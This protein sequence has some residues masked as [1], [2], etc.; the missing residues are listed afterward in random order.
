MAEHRPAEPVDLAALARR[1]SVAGVVWSHA[2]SDLN[3][4]FVLFEAGEG[5][6]EHVNDEVEV[7]VVA[8]VGAGFVEV[9]GQ[10]HDLAPGMVIAI[11][12]G[13]RRAIGSAGEQFGYLTC[14]RRRAWL[15]PRGLS[16]PGGGA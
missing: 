8:L 6:A 5:V 12:A 3:A 11:P 2:G 10:R 4:N 16:R 14:H 7:L 15:W 13:A 1:A 9:D